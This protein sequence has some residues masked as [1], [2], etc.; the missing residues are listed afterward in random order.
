MQVSRN[1]EDWS[2]ESYNLTVTVFSSTSTDTASTSHNLLIEKL[3]ITT[4]GFAAEERATALMEGSALLCRFTPYT[5]AA[6]NEVRGEVGP[7]DP[8]Q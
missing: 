6:N 3:R 7:L 8:A 5:D 4:V 2:A 1:Q